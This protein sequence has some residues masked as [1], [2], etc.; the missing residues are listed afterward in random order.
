MWI[1]TWAALVGCG[2][3]GCLKGVD[4]TC[5][6]PSPCSNLQTPCDGGE[7]RA[8][9]LAPGD[10]PPVGGPD[11]LAAPGDVVLENGR[12][13]A[14]VDALDH[15]HYVAPSGGTLLDLAPVGGADGLRNVL[16]ATGLLPDDAIHFT[17]F[18]VLDEPGVAAVQY[19]G[20]LDGHPDITV[21]T[22]YELRPCESGVRVRTEVVNREP[23]PFPLFLVDGFYW[24]GREHLPFTPGEAGFDHPSFGLSTIPDALR[25]VPWMSAGAHG[26]G[27]ASYGVT[28]CDAP[29]ITGFQ[30]TE[31]S[32]M[33]PPNRILMPRDYAVYERF[34]AVADG[35]S[36]SGPA[37]VL[38][39]VRQQMFGEPYVTLT[40]TIAPSAGSVGSMALAT[41]QVREQGGGWLTSVIPD[42]T[43][44][45]SARVPPDRRVELQV[46]AFGK[47]I[48]TIP[49]TVG[50]GDTDAGT[51][52]VPGTG[53]LVLNGLV[54]GV[55][56]DLQVFVHPATEGDEEPLKGALY[57]GW[58]TCAPLLG[59]PYGP[60]PACNRVLVHGPTRVVVPAGSYDL[61][62]VAGPFTTLAKIDDVEVTPGASLEH[63]LSV[64]SVPV[65]PP[66]T[67]SA[68]F[69]VHG[70]ASFDSA[71]PDLDR[72]R[73][74]L[75]ARIQVVAS[76]DH[77]VVN[78][79][80]EAVELL[81]ADQELRLL[82]GL[83]TTGH[84]LFPLDETT[85]YPKVI[86]HF[87]F[88]PLPYDAEGPWR[89]APWDELAEPGLLFDRVY[90]MGLA[91]TGVIQLNHPW[92]GLQFGR[93]FAWPTAIGL[94]L[95]A[96]LPP[97]YDGT[98]QGLFLRVPPG[99]VSSNAD[100]HAQEVMNGSS[101]AS[102][103][104]YRAVWHYLLNEGVLRAGTANS[105]SHSLADNVLGTPRTLV[106]TDTTLDDWDEA[107]FDASVRAG[108]MIGTNG[109]LIQIALVD[110][111]GAVAHPSLT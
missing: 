21:A 88:W 82:V 4:E 91:E 78:D 54:D 98:G 90:D 2:D 22:R 109:P 92:G 86:G 49:V 68:D 62:A 99:A 94:D 34:I 1:S 43:G 23:D 26:D 103:Q 55:V 63:T 3:E 95:T 29:T 39:G 15:P 19:K 6:V 58:E 77:D 60:S 61:Y 27:A 81:G 51:L 41:V 106:W 85:I 52:E 65:Q 56:D 53:E 24:G 33:G 57:G 20:S 17:S 66:G 18:E 8:Y 107:T 73:A 97:T 80:A 36:T 108:T 74:F 105:D 47:G 38:L 50:G 96:P 70:R 13:V 67:L 12:V 64:E 84:V 69:H 31:L 35:P 59:N 102:F 11:A 72:V 37:D 5:V 25:A 46:E 45:F 32:A 83:E 28:A 93:D 16:Q 89:G 111:G 30:S 48:A 10:P 76:T 9:V 44:R 110:P 71:L 42:G 101:N 79:Y 14:V 104:Q 75:A 7:V 87:N 40:G 100:Y